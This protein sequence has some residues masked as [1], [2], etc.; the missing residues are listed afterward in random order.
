MLPPTS[1]ISN[2]D[3]MLRSIAA[4]A[5]AVESRSLSKQ[6]EVENARAMTRNL[7]ESSSANSR[8]SLNYILFWSINGLWLA[9]FVAVVVWMW[10]FNGLQYLSGCAQRMAGH[11][12]SDSSDGRRQEETEQKSVSPETRSKLLSDYFRKAKVHMV[13]QC[14]PYLI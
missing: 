4:S 5:F 13:S 10:R 14:F 2:K 6:I 12:E 7:L 1:F 9:L 11:V 3:T 8:S